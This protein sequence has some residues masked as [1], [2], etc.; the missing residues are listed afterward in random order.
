[1]NDPA[2][3]LAS[4]IAAGI[5]RKD[6]LPPELLQHLAGVIEFYQDD[7]RESRDPGRTV[8]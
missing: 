3:A 5:V 2:P 4:A 1:M 8:T 6:G 7:D